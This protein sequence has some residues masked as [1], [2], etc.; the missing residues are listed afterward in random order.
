M[1]VVDKNTLAIR[2]ANEC[3]AAFFLHDQDSFNGASIGE[4]VGGDAELMLAQVW[5]NAAAGTAGHPFL[6]RGVIAGQPRLLIVRATKVPADG[7]MLRLFTFVDAPAEQPVPRPDWQQSVIDVLDGLPCAIEIAD[8][9]DE[10][11][12]ANAETLKLFGYGQDDLG[13]PDDWWRLAYPEPEYREYA[14][15]KWT[16]EIQAAR[17]E[18]REMTPFDLDVVTASG[19]VRTIQFRHRTIGSFNL[20][21]FLDVTRERA[22]EREL[23]ALAET[24]SLTGA[25]NRRRFF[26][27]ANTLL[28]IESASPVGVL[29]L[30]LD[31]FKEIND[32]YGHGEGDAVLQE[33]TH[34]VRHTL[35]QNDRLARL[36]GEEFAVLLPATGLE[37]AAAIAEGLRVAVSNHPFRIGGV[38]LSVNTSIGGTCCAAG[39]AIDAAISRADKAL[40]GAKRESRNRVVMFPA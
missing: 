34:C 5:N 40:Y 10:V 16:A 35:R 3:A 25:M 12:F 23:R 31:R 2:H 26:E 1:L 22:Y 13:S 9:R 32:V 14:K 38:R 24:D 19:E 6:V 36:G 27:E 18:N 17:A 30:D 39:G 28:A 4:I 21:L 20:N 29:M 8:N 11:Q 33:F 37:A 7:D 15:Q